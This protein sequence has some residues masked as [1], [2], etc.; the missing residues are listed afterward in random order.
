MNARLGWPAALAVAVLASACGGSSTAELDRDALAERLVAAAPQGSKTLLVDALGRGRGTFATSPEAS[1]QCEERVRL[2]W[3]YVPENTSVTVTAQPDAASDFVSWL[4]HCSGTEPCVLSMDQTRAV[5]AKFEPKAFTARVATWGDGHGTI[6]SDVGHACSTGSDEGCAVAVPNATPPQV[7]T[8]TATAAADSELVG[9]SGVCQGSGASCTVTLTSDLDVGAYFKP[10][11]YN[12]TVSIQGKGTGRVTGGPIACEGGVCSGAAPREEPLTL[13]ATPT[14]DSVFVGWAGACSGTGSCTVTPRFSTTVIALFGPP[15]TPPP[16]SATVASVRIMDYESSGYNLELIAEGPGIA[17]ASVS[18][19]NVAPSPLAAGCPWTS[20]DCYRAVR[21]FGPV[22][23]TPGSLY[24][25]SVAY[26]DG[27]TEQLTATVHDITVGYPRPVSP[28]EYEVTTTTTPTFSWL[29]PLTGCAS[30]YRVSVS[31]AQTNA[32]LWVTRV[33][34]STTSVQYNFD[35]AASVPTLGPG[36]YRWNLIAFDDCANAHPEGANTAHARGTTFTVDSLAA[37]VVT[38]SEFVAT[39]T[40]QT[41]RYG[42]TATL[43]RNGFV[44][45]TGGQPGTN[46]PMASAELWDPATRAFTATGSMV[47]PRVQHTATLLPNGL[48]LIAGG[49]SDGSSELYDPATGTFAATGSMSTRRA[50]HTATLLRDG[51]V[52]LIG[53]QGQFTSG[54]PTAELYDPASGSFSPTGSMAAGRL[55]HAATLLSDGKVLVAGGQPGGAPNPAHASAELYDP[56]TGRFEPVGSM[57]RPR[58]AF[59]SALLPNGHVLVVGGD[60]NYTSTNS[61]EIY[62]PVT[63][64][65]TA[66]GSMTTARERATATTLPD[67]TVLI[68][69]GAAMVAGSGYGLDTSEIFHP[70]SGAFAMGPS[71]VAFRSGQTATAFSNGRVLM[72]GGG[73]IVA[74]VF[75]PPSI[76]VDQ[77]YVPT[78]LDGG[79]GI[80]DTMHLRGQTFTTGISGNLGAV[81]L[82]LNSCF[83]S[84]TS[85]I[86]VTIRSGMDSS[87]AILASGVIPS[88]A[89]P[90]VA[91]CGAGTGPTATFVH[92]N[93]TSPVYVQSGEQ[94][95]IWAASANGTDEYGWWGDGAGQ[96]SGG[97]AYTSV[98]GGSGSPYGWPPSYADLGF[99][100]YVYPAP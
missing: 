84:N 44:L 21:S 48:V 13:T 39:G 35:G 24:S 55:I 72:T 80:R 67:G 9:W 99:R 77:Q 2:C 14:G 26:A 83:A 97:V 81:D 71:M 30:L 74:E 6:T 23:P 10:R 1:L 12:L 7:V 51:R 54:M 94:Y 57:T 75:E 11:A 90:F 70:G 32:L 65:F 50:F 91:G 63:R 53:G 96:Y 59:A 66:T 36:T 62:D 69:G 93:L 18:G 17:Q 98:N 20:V 87:G 73:A 42:H 89:V 27:R 22:K 76:V 15:S 41:Q 45:V 8:L 85:E 61:A 60:D 56:S 40:M 19:P 3:A 4:G 37:P 29:P 43:L 47:R 88:S 68:A 38:T 5:M 79:L 64:A 16:P 34:G 95:G 25:F 82:L 100:T 46:V 92:V 78:V 86:L 49:T 58:T 52:L 28:A 31:S 33:P